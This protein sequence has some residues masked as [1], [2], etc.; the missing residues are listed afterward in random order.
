MV[1]GGIAEVEWLMDGMGKLKGGAGGK[2]CSHRRP[3]VI[4]RVGKAR[5]E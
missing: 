4:S 2:V 1:V 5:A 3:V